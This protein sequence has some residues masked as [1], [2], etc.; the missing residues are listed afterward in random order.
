M[1]DDQLRDCWTQVHQTWMRCSLIIAI[2]HFES[3]FMIGQSVVEC[4]KKE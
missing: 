2:E 3:G 1:N 4:Q